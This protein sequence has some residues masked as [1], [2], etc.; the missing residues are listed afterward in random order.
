M[1]FTEGFYG[2]DDALYG[3]ARTHHR[4][5]RAQRY[6]APHRVPVIST[7]RCVWIA[8]RDQVRGVVDARSLH[9]R[10][11]DII[12][13]DGVTQCFGDGWGL[14]RA[15]NTTCSCSVRGAHGPAFLRR[16][17]VYGAW[18]RARGSG[19]TIWGSRRGRSNHARRHRAGAGGGEH[20]SL[21]TR[22]T[23]GSTPGG[24]RRWRTMYAMAWG[25]AWSREISSF[26]AC[27]VHRRRLLHPPAPGSPVS[28]SAVPL[29]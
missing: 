19:L 18:L 23:S 3:A 22:T 20:H 14:I 25:S 15:S 5:L 8:R 2:H 28:R 11:H 24:I 26:S 1:F 13:V 7:R 9:F 4:G 27:A 16:F 29:R 12:D 21:N 17:I 6:R 10:S